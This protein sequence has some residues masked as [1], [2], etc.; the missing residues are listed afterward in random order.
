MSIRDW[1]PNPPTGVVVV[2]FAMLTAAALNNH[3]GEANRAYNAAGQEQGQ[4][5][6]IIP[7]IGVREGPKGPTTKHKAPTEEHRAYRDLQAQEEM[8][9]WAFWVFVATGAG[10]LLLG[11]TLYETWKA[12]KA[13]ATTL[14]QTKRQ[15]D[16]AEQSFRRLERPYLFIRIL[17][18]K[19]LA[20]PPSGNTAML[21]YTLVN[22]GKLPAIM[23]G[24]SVGLLNNPSFP[25]RSTN[26]IIDPV[27]DV[28]APAETLTRDRNAAVQGADMG[29][30]FT[31]ANATLLF[32]YGIIEY[33]DPT[34][35]YHTDSFLM[36]GCAGGKTFRVYGE[37]EYN[38]RKTDYP[39]ET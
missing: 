11:A 19:G 29:E 33:E 24:I 10:V 31:S 35:A 34:G 20:R 8:A 30:T 12:G 16:L 9:E 13:V 27:Y 7:P 4:S 28:V 39:A 21:K 37:R 17:D 26:E 3:H 22:Y 36:Q 38:W 6:P 25:I 18:T 15:A 5:K 1:V 14:A 32:L 2:V 23:K